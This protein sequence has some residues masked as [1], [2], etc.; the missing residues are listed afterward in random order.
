MSPAELIGYIRGVLSIL[1]RSS[2]RTFE[3]LSVNKLLR[4]DLK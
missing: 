2:K 1:L 4:G 3:W